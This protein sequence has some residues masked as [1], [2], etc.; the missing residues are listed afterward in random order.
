MFNLAWGLLWQDSSHLIKTSK[1]RTIFI[2]S[3]TPKPL[4]HIE[5]VWHIYTRSSF[6]ACFRII[7]LLSISFYMYINRWNSLEVK[8]KSMYFHYIF[9][10][11]F[12]ATNKTRTQID[13]IMDGISMSNIAQNT[14]INT[15]IFLVT[16]R[17]KKKHVYILC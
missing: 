9:P 2:K 14:H 6:I 11:T 4:S 12:S 16:T 17:K 7:H 8:I 1:W 13:P 3:H 15:K 10:S 5:I